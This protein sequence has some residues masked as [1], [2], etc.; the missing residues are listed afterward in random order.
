MFG[1]CGVG[2]APVR[3]GAEGY[4][5][6]LMEGVEDIPGTVLAEGVDFRWQ[7]FP[8]YLDVLAETLQRVL[9][10]AHGVGGE[11]HLPPRLARPLGHVPP[12]QTLAESYYYVKQMQARTPIVVILTDGEVLRGT[13]EWYDKDCIKITRTGAPNLLVYKTSIKYVYKD[14]DAADATD[15]PQEPELAHVSKEND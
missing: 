2:F 1:N 15:E 10:V 13:I 6:T 5:I 4:L 9:Q 3:P 14:E 12:E 7:S 11:P 8:D